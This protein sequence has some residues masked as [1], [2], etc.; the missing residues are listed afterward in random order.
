MPYVRGVPIVEFV[1]TRETSL[2]ERLRLALHV[3][4][5]I[6]SAHESGIIHRDIKSSNVLVTDD[7]RVVLLDFGIGKVLDVLTGG[8]GLP[9]VTPVGVRLLTPAN[10]APEQV[11][12][13]AAGAHTDVYGVGLLLYRLLAGRPALD[14][15][16][17][18][19]LQWE[20]TVLEV[21]P[22]PPSTVAEGRDPE[23]TARLREQLQGDLDGIVM[24]AL[25]K[26]PSDRHG[27]MHE[28]AMDIRRYLGE[29]PDGVRPGPRS[30]S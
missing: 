17:K 8:D 1:E 18:S 25:S 30:G 16:G 26:G 13:Q 23:E 12:G 14:P 24:K 20:R 28:L 7:R 4:E 10:A 9:V 6:Q 15:A 5:A 29:S 3:C 27:S 21:E 2:H 11:D 19:W 22:L